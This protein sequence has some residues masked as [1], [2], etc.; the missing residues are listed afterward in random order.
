MVYTIN[1]LLW[2]PGINMIFEIHSNIPYVSD[3]NKNQSG[4]PEW[5][6]KH[7]LDSCIGKKDNCV[8]SSICI[9]FR[10]IIIFKQINL[11]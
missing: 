3:I 6:G 4:H 1:Y 10:Q 5:G 11:K 2:F 9:N 7:L 8:L